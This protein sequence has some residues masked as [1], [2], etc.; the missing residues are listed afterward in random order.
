MWLVGLYLLAAIA[1]NL[2]VHRRLDL[3]AWG[4]V[5]IEVKYAK[6]TDTEMNKGFHFAISKKQASDGLVADLVMFICDYG[7]SETYHIFPVQRPV[8]QRTI[9]SRNRAILY[10][11]SHMKRHQHVNSGKAMLTKS[12]MDYYQDAWHLIE[13][14]RENYAR[15][16]QGL[17]FIELPMPRQL[18]L[19]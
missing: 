1:A 19:I 13:L 5:K 14:V 18:E 9:R 4:C 15:Q 12:M 6:F 16:L 3:I 2:S 10:V 7:D 11:P 17:E 8:I